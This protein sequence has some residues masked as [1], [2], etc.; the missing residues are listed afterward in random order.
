MAEPF[1]W[2][3]EQGS[4]QRSGTALSAGELGEALWDFDIAAVD[5]LVEGGCPGSSDHEP[6]AELVLA[7]TSVADVDLKFGLRVGS[8]FGR[9]EFV[10]LAVNSFW[11]LESRT[12]LAELIL[13]VRTEKAVGRQHSRRIESLLLRDANLTAWRPGDHGPARIRV[14]VAGFARD[15]RS[16][17][18]LRA[19]E[20]RY[21]KLIHHLP[22]ALLQ[23][24]G[25]DMSPVYERMRSECIRDPASYLDARPELIAFA[26]AKVRI[27]EINESAARLL[28]AD[29]H[30][31]LGP[32]QPLFAVAPDAARRVLVARLE[33]RRN[34]SEKMKLRTCDGRLLDVRMSVT[35][36]APPEQ[37]DVTLISL[38]DITDQLRLEAQLRQIQADFSRAARISTLGELTTSIAH[39][40]NQ[41]LSAIIANAEASLRWLAREDPN[42]DKV[43]HLTNRIVGGARRANEIVQRIRGMA[44]RHAPEQARIDLNEVV[45][46]ALLFIAH[47]LETRS[48]ELSLELATPLPLVLGDRVQLQQVIVNLLVNGVQAQAETGEGQGRIGIETSVAANGDVAV[49]VRDWGGGIEAENMARLFQSF[50]T[51][52]PDGMGIG[53]AICQSIV[54]AHGGTI[55]ASNHADGGARFRFTLPPASSADPAIH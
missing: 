9:E 44:A 19:S 14:K 30:A 18:A 24:D 25:R 2:S 43:A 31:L 34:H 35:F 41:P 1:A 27:T 54:T 26:L 12:E 6:W 48:I 47:D 32:I 46:E 42:L 11:P 40:V 7:N 28:G 5:R 29:A 39:E 50:Y 53:L 38:E 22:L 49:S 36:P 16:N 20:E 17:W 51:T 13:A 45:H 10:G 52:K 8:Y 21:R 33:G 3:I 55:G 15:G 4:R 23:V 37:A